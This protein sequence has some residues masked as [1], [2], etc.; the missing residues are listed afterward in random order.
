M[1]VDRVAIKIN[2]MDE[3]YGILKDLVFNL[4]CFC[5]EEYQLSELLLPFETVAK[6]SKIIG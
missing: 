3:E 2:R 6:R 5:F 1:N 4:R